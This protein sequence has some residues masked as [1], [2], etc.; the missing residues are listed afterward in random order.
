MSERI[1][2]ALVGPGA[3]GCAVAGAL[4]QA[5]HTPFIGGRSEF[6]ELQVSTPD[7]T[8]S[9]PLGCSAN[10]ADAQPADAVV[11]AVKAHQTDSARAWLNALVDDET[12]VFVLQNGVEHVERLRSIVGA[13]PQIEPVVVSLPA[14]RS[15]PGRCHVSAAS[16]L[17]IPAGPGGDRLAE[18]L[19]G[20]YIDVRR[21]DDWISAAWVKLLLNAALGGIAVL[22]HTDNTVF[23]R[24]DDARDLAVRLMAEIIDV[25]RA[26]GATLGDDLPNQ[27]IEGI[28]AVAA[29]HKSS[30]VVDRI[31]GVATEWDAR[32]AV[33]GRIGRRHGI[34]TPLNDTLTT[35]IRVGEP[36]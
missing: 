18:L 7:D 19:N 11:L 17:T 34:P 9:A 28:L 2:V 31:N 13:G 1:A 6:S 30:I 20:S 22:G 36:V 29:G 25:G 26:E 21:S 12:T 4:V 3:I 33:V 27:I 14:E 32:N 15:A 10:P 35:L 8:F 5:G 24:D 23:G 16:R